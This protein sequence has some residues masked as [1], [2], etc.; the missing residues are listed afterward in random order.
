M[1]EGCGEAPAAAPSHAPG[2]LYGWSEGEEL[3]GLAE[4]RDAEVK[5]GPGGQLQ[6]CKILKE[7]YFVKMWFGILNAGRGGQ[8]W[9]GKGVDRAG[10]RYRMLN[11]GM[12]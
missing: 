9:T 10:K 12:Q 7:S 1:E 6:S 2:C 4:V 8:R 3:A 11:A 5:G